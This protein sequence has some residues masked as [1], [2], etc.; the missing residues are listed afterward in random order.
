MIFDGRGKRHIIIS[1]Q[2]PTKGEGED[3]IIASCRNQNRYYD[4]PSKKELHFVLPVEASKKIYR[5]DV[6]QSIRDV[7]YVLIF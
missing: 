3:I 7:E 2:H 4:V 6:Y 5:V 1:Q